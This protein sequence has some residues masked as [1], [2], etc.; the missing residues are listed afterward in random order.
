LSDDVLYTLA[1]KAGLSL[2][3]TDYLGNDRTVAA[4]VLRDVL[5]TMQLP[6]ATTE[7]AR[8]SLERLR[9]AAQNEMPSM[10]VTRCDQA[11]HLPEAAIKKIKM[12]A[13]VRLI[14]EDESP[15][16]IKLETN[17]FGHVVL[18]PLHTPGYH[19]LLIGDEK[20]ALAVAPHRAYSISDATRDT[21]KKSRLW[22]LS[23]Q[24]Y[25]LRRA[26]SDHASASVFGSSQPGAVQLSDGGFGDFTALAKLA[27]AAQ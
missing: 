7:D 9:I 8:A 14:H 3:W 25:S 19:T 24:L 20:I 6:A 23:A 12:S 16:D 17:E 18:P 10:L 11:T 26:P 15:L 5:A 1:E 13:L 22:G 27:R 2:R 4:D 21:G